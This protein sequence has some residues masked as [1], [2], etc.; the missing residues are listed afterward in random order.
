MAPKAGKTQNVF[1][2]SPKTTKIA[3]KCQKSYKIEYLGK[4]N[5]PMVLLSGLSFYEEH[6]DLD[7]KNVLVATLR[8]CRFWV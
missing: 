7:R 3:K 2:N 5:D 6:V 1:K 8:V 4:T